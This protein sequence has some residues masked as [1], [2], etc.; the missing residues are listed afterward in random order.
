MTALKI[1][2]VGNSLGVILPKEIQDELELSEGDILELTKI[3]H[4]RV[5][6]ES[7]LPHHSEWKFKEGKN[8]GKKG[9]NKLTTE[10]KEWDEADLEEGAYVPKW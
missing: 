2:K 4:K 10:E 7:P 5:L 6:L 1:R 9:G 8:D 3:S